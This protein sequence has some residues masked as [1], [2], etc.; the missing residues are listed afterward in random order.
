MFGFG[1]KKSQE[2][3]TAPRDQSGSKT[4][5]PTIP[6]DRFTV[7]PGEYVPKGPSASSRHLPGKKGLL[8]GG[9]AVLVLAVFGAVLFAVL[10]SGPDVARDAEALPALTQDI[11]ANAPSILETAE[12]PARVSET[13]IQSQAFDASGILIGSLAVTVPPTVVQEYGSGIGVT[14]LAEEDLTLPEEGTVLGGLY[15]LYPAGVTFSEPLSLLLSAVAAPASSDPGDAFP[16]YL[17]GVRWQE[18]PDYQLTTEGYAFMLEKAP[19]GPIAVIWHSQE[20]AAT[21]ELSFTRAIPTVDTDTDGLTDAE[22]ALFGTSAASADS[23]SDSY[24]DLEEIQNGYSPLTPLARLS[25]SG[26]FATYTNATY[27]Y[28]V[29]YP[30]SWLADSLDQ[31]NKQVLFISNT[32]E[33][34]E[35]LIVENPLNT[36]IVDWFRAQSPSLANVELD[37][38]VLSGAPAVW[39]PDHLTAYASS[40]GLIYILTYNNGTSDEINWPNVFRHFYSSFTFGAT[41]TSPEQAPQN[42]EAALGE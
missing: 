25:E 41:S 19:S 1:K 30:A 27:G 37:V 17:R 18:F 22:E 28:R 34:F 11:Q 33:F 42:E 36:P 24:L 15:S 32:E 6:D 20:A 8:L 38:A 2:T 4:A 29:E 23:D 39:S 16:A 26:L 12:E 31:T 9:S 14:L 13:A 7:M 35:V 21:E 10:R 40:G 5:T 3:Q